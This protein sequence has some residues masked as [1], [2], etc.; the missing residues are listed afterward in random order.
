MYETRAGAAPPPPPESAKLSQIQFH[1]PS[2]VPPVLANGKTPNRCKNQTTLLFNYFI[3]LLSISTMSQT[4]LFNILL[5]CFT[6]IY[7]HYSFQNR[8]EIDK[9]IKVKA[10]RKDIV[11]QNITIRHIN[12]QFDDQLF[13][14]S[15][16]RRRLCRNFSNA[17]WILD[18]GTSSM[19][20]HIITYCFPSVNQS[21][22][23]IIR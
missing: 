7:R 1:K 13:S 15:T 21:S 8:P 5:M 14:S 9:L 11:T 12:P 23:R 17:N 4:L 18:S 3:V 2:P 6:R 16:K 19:K 22:I 20:I 10:I